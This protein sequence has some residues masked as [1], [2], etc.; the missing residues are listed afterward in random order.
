MAAFSEMIARLE[1]QALEEGDG[2]G[3]PDLV[4]DGEQTPAPRTQIA[5]LLDTTGDNTPDGRDVVINLTD[6]VV[7]IEDMPIRGHPHGFR[8]TVR[9]GSEADD[10][11]IVAGMHIAR[12]TPYHGDEP[13]EELYRMRDKSKIQEALNPANEEVTQAE[14]MFEDPQDYANVFVSPSDIP[15]P[16]IM[17]SLSFGGA[18]A[19]SSSEMGGKPSASMLK[20]PQTPEGMSKSNDV[21]YMLTMDEPGLRL[22]AMD[23]LLVVTEVY[24]KRLKEI[25]EGHIVQS[26]TIYYRNKKI[27]P[28]K[29]DEADF[30]AKV[31]AELYESGGK[32][33][34]V[35]LTL[36]KYSE[37]PLSPRGI[38]RGR[39]MTPVSPPKMLR[40]PDMAV[41]S[42]MC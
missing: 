30:A 23:G 26:A 13:Q 34:K 1:R 8:H 35:L 25:A 29:S 9:P 38:K 10:L 2:E 18:P 33:E 5:L 17:G 22:D 12:V 19:P 14:I 40:D 7:E 28:M 16:P 11:G 41:F 42:D 37:S 15:P 4:I 20:S 24:D 39:S 31:V 21:R 3:S 36:P 6:L 32:V 27:V